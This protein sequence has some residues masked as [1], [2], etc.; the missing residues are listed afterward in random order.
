MENPKEGA[1][2]GWYNNVQSQNMVVGRKRMIYIK[3]SKFMQY[4]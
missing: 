3:A 1:A 2:M 4:Q